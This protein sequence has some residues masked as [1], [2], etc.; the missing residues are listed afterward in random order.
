M[1]IHSI[2]GCCAPFAKS[3]PLMVER[4]AWSIV[5]KARTLW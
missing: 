4:C 3:M 1:R 5:W 2:A